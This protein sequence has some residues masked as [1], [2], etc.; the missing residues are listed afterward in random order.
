[1]KKK[2]IKESPE[3]YYSNHKI[4]IEFTLNAPS[5]YGVIDCMKISLVRYTTVH[6][7]DGNALESDHL[8]GEITDISLRE[9][10]LDHFHTANGIVEKRQTADSFFT[11]MCHSFRCWLLNISKKIVF[12]I[13]KD[14]D[15]VCS[16][17]S[18]DISQDSFSQNFV[19]L[20]QIPYALDAQFTNAFNNYEMASRTMGG[21]PWRKNYFLRFF[22]KNHYD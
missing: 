18:S 1:M 10:S 6:P 22:Y 14:E 15:P 8:T 4:T 2:H 13:N 17:G 20:S 16:I 12:R 5:T 19:R 21:W 11:E 9:E 3:I 7:I